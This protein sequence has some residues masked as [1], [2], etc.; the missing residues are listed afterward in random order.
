MVGPFVLRLMKEIGY[1]IKNLPFLAVI[2]K[3]IDHIFV[4]QKKNQTEN[5]SMIYFMTVK[6][7]MS[8]SQEFF[9]RIKSK[10]AED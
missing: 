3:E 9:R 5:I 4:E 6:R 7:I 8:D 10:Q 1:W 2:E